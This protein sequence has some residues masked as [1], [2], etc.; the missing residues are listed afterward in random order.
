MVTMET[1]VEEL[2]TLVINCGKDID[3]AVNQL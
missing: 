3:D 2:L 1:E